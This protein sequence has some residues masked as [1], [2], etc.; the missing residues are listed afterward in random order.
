MT[1]NNPPTSTSWVPGT[2][3][4]GH[5]ASAGLKVICNHQTDSFPTPNDS[6]TFIYLYF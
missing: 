2:T 3:V 4:M 1:S 5:C 6:G